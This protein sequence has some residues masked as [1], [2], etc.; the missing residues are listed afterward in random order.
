MDTSSAQNA[1]PPL[2]F[3]LRTLL[4]ITAVACVLLAPYHWFGPVYLVS[5][6]ASATLV[7]CCIR[8]YASGSPAL[9]LVAAGSGAVTG[10]FL[11][12]GIPTFFLHAL[13]NLGVLA[14]V[15]LAKPRVRTLTVV[16]VLTAFTIY[17]FA[18]RNSYDEYRKQLEMQAKYPIES[19]EDRLDFDVERNLGVQQPQSIQPQTLSPVVLTSLTMREVDADS[20]YYRRPSALERLHSESRLR[21]QVAAGF[22]SAR[23]AYVR[24]RNLVDEPRTPQILPLAVSAGYADADDPN[25]SRE[26]H[27]DVVLDFLNPEDFGYVASQRKAAGFISHGFRHVESSLRGCG[28]QE[29][30]WQL[31][32]LELV[33]LLRHDPPRVYESDTLPAMDQ[34]EEI[35]HR[36]LDQFETDA[37]PQLEFR[38]D[39]VIQHAPDRIRMLGSLRA[40]NDCL[41]CHSV[42]R[43]ELL[44]AFS[45]EL[46]KIEKPSEMTLS[47]INR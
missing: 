5:A 44:G 27:A 21:F 41:Q 31:T 15:L 7:F 30:S 3:S 39:L 26:L 4:T 28:Q 22:G 46:V 40:S 32:R 20:Y 42:S 35:P 10:L 17:G 43:G 38:R 45:Y 6:I 14:L 16:L 11:V 8:G 24:T 33:S 36:S 9:A 25:A 12:L 1:R 34:L 23:M 47:L 19:L 18:F 2:R 13:A 29:E 37:L